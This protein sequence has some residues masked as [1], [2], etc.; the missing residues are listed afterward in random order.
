MCDLLTFD[1]QSR[2]VKSLVEG[3][4]H[5]HE[6]TE[7]EVW[8]FNDLLERII[9]IAQGALQ[10]YEDYRLGRLESAPPFCYFFDGLRVFVFAV[11]ET[12]TIG[13]GLQREK[14]LHVQGLS[15]L[16]SLLPPM[17]AIVSEDDLATDSAFFGG[18]L[19]HY[20]DQSP[21]SGHERP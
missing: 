11:E 2:G 3:W 8:P 10:A 12:I 4:R 5:A 9:L 19:D 20:H 18:A 14:S 17:R 13:E 15:E 6:Q 7:R 16:R 21:N 1:I